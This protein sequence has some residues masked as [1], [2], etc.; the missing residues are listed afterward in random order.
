MSLL[1]TFYCLIITLIVNIYSAS[2][3]NDWGYSD[4]F[5]DGWEREYQHWKLYST[6]LFPE[7]LSNKVTSY[8]QKYYD[9][10][11]SNDLLYYQFSLKYE[12]GIIVYINGNEIYR[13]DLSETSDENT[14]PTSSILAT[15]TLNV[16]PYYFN[17]EI[18]LL[19]IEIHSVSTGKDQFDL[20]I[21]RYLSPLSSNQ[22]LVNPKIT[23]YFSHP[24]FTSSTFNNSAS[25]LI[26]GI[27]NTVYFAN[28][29]YDVSALFY[30]SIPTTI[31]TYSL[32]VASNYCC[33]DPGKWIFQGVKTLPNRGFDL[34]PIEEINLFNLTGVVE[35]PKCVSTG[36]DG[37]E[38]PLKRYDYE[39]D[40]KRVFNGFQWHSLSSR[41]T[42]C[43]ITEGMQLAEL[44]VTSEMVFFCRETSIQ[45]GG[46]I[47]SVYTSPCQY[48]LGKFKYTCE[49]FGSWSKMDDSECS[50]KSVII[51]IG[52][53]ELRCTKNQ[54]L[55][56]HFEI[57]SSSVDIVVKTK[58]GSILYHHVTKLLYE[59]LDWNVCVE[60]DDY[61][62]TV[63]PLHNVTF[64]YSVKVDGGY[65]LQNQINKLF[66]YYE[67]EFTINK[68]KGAYLNY[69]VKQFF[70]NSYG[71]LFP[72]VNNEGCFEFTLL[73]NIPN[74]L[75]FDTLTGIFSGT[76]TSVY[77]QS[78]AVKCSNPV[79]NTFQFLLTSVSC[80]SSTY[81]FYVFIT[82]AN[83]ESDVVVRLAHYN[84]TNIE[85][86][87]N[88]IPP[89]RV[90]YRYGCFESISYILTGSSTTRQSWKSG[91]SVKYK[92]QS[93]LSTLPAYSGGDRIITGSFISVPKTYQH[94]RLNKFNDKYP[95]GWT[96]DPMSWPS[97][98]PGGFNP[99]SSQFSAYLYRSTFYHLDTPNLLY[100]SIF[101]SFQGSAIIFLNGNE[102]W[103]SFI[104]YDH[105]PADLPDQLLILTRTIRVLPY[106][107][108]TGNNILAVE[109]HYNSGNKDPFYMSI[110]PH[111]YY[112]DCLPLLNINKP[113][114]F[115]P[116]TTG[117]V[118]HTNMFDN[119]YDTLFYTGESEVRVGSW[120]NI[121]SSAPNSGTN[122]NRYDI[123]MGPDYCDRDVTSITLSGT[124]K[125]STNS[126]P[127]YPTSNYIKSVNTN[128]NL[129]EC[130]G[131]K[132]NRQN[133]KFR[134][135][136]YFD[137]GI[138]FEG[139]LTTFNSKSK[140]GMSISEFQVYS[141]K[142]PKCI[143]SKTLP[144]GYYKSEVT[145]KCKY[146]SVSVKFIC[147]INGEWVPSDASKCGINMK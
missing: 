3:Y 44:E 34:D 45:P 116:K 24:G 74:G 143:A 120:F 115:S 124:T 70:L 23:S 46:Y 113:F 52:Y 78:V 133:P 60:E 51:K 146:N 95:N 131:N 27:T 63:V 114:Y 135:A 21:S 41:G 110:T 29:K 58:S 6:D 22:K 11:F 57:P 145:A 59:V 5:K 92:F 50:K 119:S 139:L 31:S 8:Y 26:D 73:S 103:R 38:D 81:P 17:D 109:I 76:L 66:S 147:N 117:E 48:G 35:A 85:F 61:I 82:T 80:P 121:G 79:S 99:R 102:I 83:T 72:I 69:D 96:T 37:R 106:G 47:G 129:P 94:Y 93:S 25:K 118:I 89:N 87:L 19:S 123:V 84:D 104:K 86:V 56:I 122:A 75:S 62:I 10:K 42:G 111:L 98:N 142:I 88:N 112:G 71:Q 130:I 32:T 7:K 140:M 108:A 15:R 101:I 132:T 16:L 105:K 90:I 128:K 134:Y 43:Q 138:A 30:F 65:L 107:L 97:Y 137:N 12:G 40:N 18:N 91:T 2:I 141:C 28:G 1:L 20:K 9:L 125:E 77:S 126:Q 64:S 100:Y 67:V 39:L 144:S 55:N 36:N 127:S 54:N 13:S 49:G 14:L 68:R 136:F 33:R 53:E 4:T